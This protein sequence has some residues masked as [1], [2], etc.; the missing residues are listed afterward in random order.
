FTWPR[1][2]PSSSIPPRRSIT[3]H[4]VTTTADGA[5][6]TT[7]GNSPNRSARQRKT[8]AR[9]R[10]CG[11]C[12]LVHA[13]GIARL[14]DNDVAQVGADDG[15]GPQQPGLDGGTIFEVSVDYQLGEGLVDGKDGAGVEVA[16]GHELAQVPAAVSPLRSVVRADS[17][18]AD[19][20]R[21]RDVAVQRVA[22]GEGA[23]APV[24]PGGREARGAAEGA[25]DGGLADRTGAVD[26]VVERVLADDRGIA[27]AGGDFRVA[28]VV[29]GDDRTDVVAD[30]EL[31]GADG[32]GPD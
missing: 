5:D 11:R 10:S 28:N 7:A 2:R 24:G 31:A 30:V 3:R 26:A 22:G 1:R 32:V 6:T 14:S 23:D 8:P 25:S 15:L 9:S 16:A 29:A 13:R 12:H 27:A 21:R 20:L 4:R 18:G 19:V 17:D